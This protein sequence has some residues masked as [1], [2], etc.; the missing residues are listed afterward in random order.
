KLANKHGVNYNTLESLPTLLT[1]ADIV[2]SS[3][4]SPDFI[5]TKSM[6]EDVNL[7]RKASSLLLID[8]AVPRDIEP[9]VNISENI[10]SYDVDDLKGL[11]DANLR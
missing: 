11:V 2:I 7:Q 10:F 1:D 9:D 8:I 4:S 6:I 5:V 3:T